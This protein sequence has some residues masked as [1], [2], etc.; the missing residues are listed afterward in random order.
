MSASPETQVETGP[1][2]TRQGAARPALDLE[3]GLPG[4]PFLRSADGAWSSAYP[5]K[6]LRCWAVHPTA[7]PTVQKQR[8]LCVSA[9]H[10]TCATFVAAGADSPVARDPD[11]IDLWPD[12]APAP[13]ALESVR[14]RAGSGFRAPRL[15]GQLVLAGVLLVALVV[16]LVANV[17]PLGGAGASTPPAA[18]PSAAS[19]V[20]GGSPAVTLA[21]TPTAIITP[22]PAAP[23]PT[24]A[25]TR[26]PRPT[27]SPRTYKVK[28]GDTIAGIAAKLHSTVKAIVTANNIVDPRTIRPGQILIVP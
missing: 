1:V 9:R 20:V 2:V 6:D 22:S 14:G 18:S 10:T 15:G 8:Q 7:L 25:P 11:G 5:A 21:P 27:A 13:V 12:A 28:P 17:N 3:H 26:T 23:T 24:V 19:A 4:C 16:V